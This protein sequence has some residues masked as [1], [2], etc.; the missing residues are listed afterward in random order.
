MRKNIKIVAVMFGTLVIAS[1]VISAVSTKLTTVSLG[2]EGET[3]PIYTLRG[4]YYSTIREYSGE[5]YYLFLDDGTFSGWFV[6]TGGYKYHVTGT[7]NIEAKQISGT[8]RI[9]A[10]TGWISGYI[11]L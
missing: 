8:W 11:G 6:A 5:T 10:V 1:A 4:F 3:Q 7:Y 9:G 2:L